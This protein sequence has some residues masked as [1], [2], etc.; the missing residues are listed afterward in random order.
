MDD[1]SVIQSENHPDPIIQKIRHGK[2]RP[3]KVTVSTEH[4]HRF[5]AESETSPSIHFTQKGGGGER[6]FFFYN[7]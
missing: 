3:E 6:H 2:E 1:I 7:G 5:S 4:H